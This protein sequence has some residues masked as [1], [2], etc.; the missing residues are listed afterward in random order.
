MSRL[1]V[2]IAIAVLALLTAGC[3]LRVAMDVAVAPDGSGVLELAVGLDEELLTILEDAG[4][5]PAVGLADALAAAPE[6]EFEDRSDEDGLVYAFSAEFDDPDGFARLV[7]EF[8]RGVD[9]ADPALFDDLRIVVEEDGSVL[10]AGSAGLLLPATP[11]VEGEGINFDTDDLEALLA[12]RGDEF[13]HS[14]LRVTLPAEP[15]AHDGDLRDGNTVTWQLPVGE[16]RSVEARSAPAPD[17]TLLIAAAVAVVA[18]AIGTVTT[19]WWRR[20]RAKR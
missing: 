19:I 17:R 13:V 8:Q 1:K 2:S 16:L 20:R 5:D 14:Q 15:I 3:Q 18:A 7:D 4:F 6:W 11:G 12:E 10:F 9:G